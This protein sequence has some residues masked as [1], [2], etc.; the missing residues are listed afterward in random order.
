MKDMNFLKQTI[1]QQEQF[2]E[3]F[4]I[5]RKITRYSAAGKFDDVRKYIRVY[6]WSSI[7]D[8]GFGEDDIN[9]FSYYELGHACWGAQHNSLDEVKDFKEGRFGRMEHQVI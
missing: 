3:V 9:N 1:Q 5:V 6:N 2:S 7:S 4:D 8:K